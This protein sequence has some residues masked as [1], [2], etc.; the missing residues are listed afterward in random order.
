MEEAGVPCAPVRTLKEVCQDPQSAVREMFPIL[1]HATAG[2]IAVTGV[3]VKMSESPGR[4]R[5][6]SPVL[7]QHTRAVLHSLLCL[8]SATLDRLTAEGVIVQAPRYAG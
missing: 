5:Y 6:A 4:V 7:G 2:E 8:D 1:R 3:P